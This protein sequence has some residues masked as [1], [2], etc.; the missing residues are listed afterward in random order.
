MTLLRDYEKVI[1]LTNGIHTVYLTFVNVCVCVC[2]CVCVFFLIVI[3]IFIRQ[4][5]F[6]NYIH[7]SSGAVNRKSFD[8]IFIFV[9]FHNTG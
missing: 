2:V 5:K 3:Y 4:A 7:L 6:M 9:E 8:A 1:L